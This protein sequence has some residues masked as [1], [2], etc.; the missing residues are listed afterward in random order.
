MA[1]WAIK[2]LEH[3]IRRRGWRSE[4]IERGSKV[5]L[6]GFTGEDSIY[7]ATN[8]YHLHAEWSGL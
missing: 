6:P 8:H 5:T 1:S 2:G 4:T 7:K 3:Y